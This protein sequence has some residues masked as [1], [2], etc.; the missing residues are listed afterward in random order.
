MYEVIKVLIDLL[1]DM[2]DEV[3]TGSLRQVYEGALK[4]LKQED[5]TWEMFKKEIE[6]MPIMYANSLIQVCD[7]LH[8]QLEQMEQKII[9]PILL[10]LGEPKL[11]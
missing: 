3:D 10:R 6:Q 11:H 8:K 4:Q 7:N 9:L 5:D 2:P 1:D